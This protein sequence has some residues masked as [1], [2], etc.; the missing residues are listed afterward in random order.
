MLILDFYVDEPACFGVPPYLSPYCRLCAG[1]MTSAGY[2]HEKIHY[3]TV[4]DWRKN[5]KTLNEEFELL[6]VIA[7]STV[8]GKYLGGKIGT[9]AEIIELLEYQKKYHKNTITLIGGPIRYASEK[10]RSKI[11][12]LG[13]ILVRGDIELY[14]H[15]ASL[16]HGRMKKMIEKAGWLEG[17]N[18]GQRRKYKD[19]VD[20]WAQAGGFLIQLHPNFPNMIL[21][22]ETYR[23]CTRNI[24]CS[25]CT[26]AYYGKPEF[27]SIA[28][29][30][31]EIRELY[32]HGARYFRLGRQADLMTYLPLMNDFVSGFPR[33]VPMHLLQLYTAIHRA[34]PDLKMLHL[35]N[36]NPGLIAT[37]P[38]ESR[39]IIKIICDYNSPGDTA[40]M[41]I[42]SVDDKVIELNDLKCDARQAMQAIEIVNE[43]GA[44]RQNGIPKLLPGL[45]FI[46]GLPGEN[47][48]TFEKNFL[49]LKSILD[50]GMLLRRINIRKVVSYENTKLDRIGGKNDS[51]FR[52]ASSLDNRFQYYRNLIRKEI[53]L[54]MLQKN[55]PP[56]TI[57]SNVILEDRNQGNYLGRPLGSYPVTI[58]IPDDDHMA[59]RVWLAQ[60]K[61]TVQPI[62]ILV[63]G[64]RE[65]SLTGL[66][67]PVSI[68]K[69]GIKSMRSIPGVGQKRAL[70]LHANLPIKDHAQYCN[71][72]E[73]KNLLSSNDCVWS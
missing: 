29:I 5:N 35:D 34:A 33:P 37:F 23:G 6:V 38:N 36:I 53:D 1:A 27:R 39:E 66:F 16:W 54:P 28:S 61:K 63:T 47:S 3:M 72:L 51:Q 73:G 55:F 11:M 10:I 59:S 44:R 22:I 42:E 62:S 43:Y 56:G 57:I 52:K 41:G 13:G 25:F 46:Q 14:V 30:E 19:E 58:K 70:K 9:V 65:R 64:S 12:S 17:K 2:P 45:N 60:K 40:A 32:N 71:I 69:M 48:K 24:F 21:E 50:S 31:N 4:D 20:I 49:F 68:N 7:G 8:P 15:K 26:E 18:T 67:Y